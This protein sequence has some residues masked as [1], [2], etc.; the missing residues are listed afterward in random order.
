MKLNPRGRLLAREGLVAELVCLTPVQSCANDKSESC[1]A[2]V[3]GSTE[4]FD[5]ETRCLSR[6]FGESDLRT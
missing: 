3:H 6:V 4:G 2:G 1:G 5:T